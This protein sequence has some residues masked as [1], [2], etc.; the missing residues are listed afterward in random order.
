MGV[1][2]LYPC[3]YFQS[4]DVFDWEMDWSRRPLADAVLQGA[5][6]IVGMRGHSSD[7]S[8]AGRLHP[9]GPGAPSLKPLTAT[10]G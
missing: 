6:K 5:E 10:I 3:T 8:C 9:A 4:N 7:P 2:R 1:N